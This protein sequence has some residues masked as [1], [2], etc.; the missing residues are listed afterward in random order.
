[1]SEYKDCPRSI[2]CTEFVDAESLAAI[3]QLMSPGIRI[4]ML[5]SANGSAIGLHG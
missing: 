2:V 4:V 1:M 3:T 5:G